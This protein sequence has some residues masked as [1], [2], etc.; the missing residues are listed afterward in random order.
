MTILLVLLLYVI[1]I[2][3]MLAFFAFLR[4]V[5]LLGCR[6][7]LLTSLLLELLEVTASTVGVTSKLLVALVMEVV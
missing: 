4:N 1:V 3:A 7:I 2:A 6:L 5:L